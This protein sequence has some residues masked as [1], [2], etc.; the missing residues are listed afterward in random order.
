MIGT[1]P[2]DGAVIAQSPGTIAFEFKISVRLTK[3]TIQADDQ[4]PKNIDLS[5]NKSFAKELSLSP[6]ALGPGSYEVE[7]RGMAEDGHVMRGSFS[8]SVK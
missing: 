3:V 6:P 7:W 4:L 5:S 2:P 8:F 1:S